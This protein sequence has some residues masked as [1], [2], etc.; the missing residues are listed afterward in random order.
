MNTKV[1]CVTVLFF[2]LLIFWGN[3]SA[4]RNECESPNN[5]CTKCECEIEV[6]V[7][8]TDS[9]KDPSCSVVFQGNIPRVTSADADPLGSLVTNQ[10]TTRAMPFVMCDVVIYCDPDVSADLTCIER[11]EYDP[12]F[13]RILRTRDKKV[14]HAIW[15]QRKC[16]V[17]C[18]DRGNR[19]KEISVKCDHWERPKAPPPV[20]KPPVKKPPV[21]NPPSKKPGLGMFASLFSGPNGRSSS[22]IT[23]FV[24]DTYSEVSSAHRESDDNDGAGIVN[25]SARWISPNGEAGVEQGV[26]IVAKGEAEAQSFCTGDAIKVGAPNMVTLP[27]CP[28]DAIGRW[29]GAYARPVPKGSSP[30]TPRVVVPVSLELRRENGS[31]TG[32]LRTSNGTFK[33]SGSQNGKNIGIEAVRTG[34]RAKISLQGTLTKDSIV[35]GANEHACEIIRSCIIALPLLYHP[36]RS[37][38][39]PR[40]RGCP[41]P[42]P[43]RTTRWSLRRPPS[44][45]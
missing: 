27:T 38:P 15:S 11:E 3:Q 37:C 36:R 16:P 26:L 40:A 42:Y 33:I 23:S 32:E 44:S 43:F 20:K 24:T 29:D 39:E 21:K 45:S 5:N 8:N 13:L 9:K 28:S 4:A 41:G 17:Y 34:T 6:T 14:K 2:T 18:V 22:M 1:L 25:D 35:F 10:I 19:V 30:G 7:K 31:L 12:G